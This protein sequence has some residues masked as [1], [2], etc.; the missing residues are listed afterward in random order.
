MSYQRNIT[1]D[2]KVYFDTDRLLRYTVYDGDPTVAEIEAG[3]AVPKDVTGYDLAWVLRKKV[4]SA[5]PPLIEKTLSS[6][7]SITGVY[8]SDPALNTQ[9]ITIQLDDTD[10][11]DPTASPPKTIKAGT[12]VYALK[13]IDAGSETILAEGT[14]T[15]LR[16][17]AWE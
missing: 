6:G 9:R 13:R 14:F 7:I 11:Y 15:L 17:A 5:D 2:D 10:T 1:A 4:D 16:A 12:Y 8:N 3:T